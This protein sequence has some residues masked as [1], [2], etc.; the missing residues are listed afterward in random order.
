MRA[1]YIHELRFGATGAA[2]LLCLLLGTYWLSGQEVEGPQPRR[3][4]LIPVFGTVERMRIDEDER[5]C[6]TL[7]V[8]VRTERGRVRATNN[9]LCRALKRLEPLPAGAPVTLLVQR[10]GA[11]NVA[12]EVT[13]GGRRLISYEW[14]HAHRAGLRRSHHAAWPLVAL[15]CLPFA[16]FLAFWLWEELSRLVRRGE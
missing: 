13:G 2:F 11:Y 5:G 14:M 16:S 15:L 8:R 10:A 4:D 6:F 1:S 12:W 7:S 3:Q 9:E